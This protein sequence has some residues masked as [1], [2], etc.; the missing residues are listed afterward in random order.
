MDIDCVWRG[1]Y[2][3][4][5]CNSLLNENSVCYCMGRTCEDRENGDANEKNLFKISHYR[6]PMPKFNLKSNWIPPVI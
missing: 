1:D 6:I 2:I 4:S 3:E 5:V